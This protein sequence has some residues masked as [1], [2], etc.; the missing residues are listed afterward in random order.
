[1]KAARADYGSKNASPFE[2]TRLRLASVLPLEAFAGHMAPKRVDQILKANHR[3]LHNIKEYHVALEDTRDL[4]EWDAGES[5]IIDEYTRH[6]HIRRTP[7]RATR[8]A[9][10]K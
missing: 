10:G 4:F 2:E 3:Y 1:M 5:D 6:L 8:P 7:P 9:R